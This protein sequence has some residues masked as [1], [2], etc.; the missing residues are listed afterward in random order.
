MYQKIIL[1]IIAGGLWANAFA[2]FSRPARA[3]VDGQLSA[4][5]YNTRVLAQGGRGCN[6][7][8]ICD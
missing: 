1:A 4:I 2:H 3:D 7:T 6:N 5:E 8:K